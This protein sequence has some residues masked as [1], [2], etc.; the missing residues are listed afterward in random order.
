MIYQWLVD[1]MCSWWSKM[2]SRWL[3]ISFWIFLLKLGHQKGDWRQSFEICQNAMSMNLLLVF[4][5]ENYLWFGCY[6]FCLDMRPETNFTEEILSISPC[7]WMNWKIPHMYVLPIPKGTSLWI[8][9]SCMPKKLIV[10]KWEPQAE[11]FGQDCMLWWQQAEAV[12]GH[13]PGG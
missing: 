13:R 1:G 9:K 3:K 2:N 10:F 5:C 12:H 6:W 11:Q 7:G 4:Q 8:R